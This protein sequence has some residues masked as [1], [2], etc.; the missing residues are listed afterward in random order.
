MFKSEKHSAEAE[1]LP[2][3]PAD[4]RW[5]EAVDERVGGRIEW[6]Q[7]LDERGNGDIG[8]RPRDLIEDLQQIE[9]NIGRP[10][11][12]EHYHNHDGHLHRLH[13]GTWNDAA[14]TG[15]A[16]SSID[17]STSICNRIAK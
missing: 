3:C 2:K 5:E 10:A 1:D 7:A 8:L 4:L 11:H 6:R 12:H 16:T 13:F 15:T 9:D 17:S 14:R